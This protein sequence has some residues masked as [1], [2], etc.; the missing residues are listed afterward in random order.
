MTAVARNFGHVLSFRRF[1][2]GT[3]KFLVLSDRTTAP[4]MRAFV[5]FICHK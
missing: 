2:L 4:V 3:A 5:G 1:A